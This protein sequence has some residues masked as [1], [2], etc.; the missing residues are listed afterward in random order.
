MPIQVITITEQIT[1]AW[2]TSALSKNGAL[3][4]GSVTSFEL[5]S[6]RGNWSAN[7]SL[8]INYTDDAQGKLPLRLFL[9][10]A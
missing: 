1:T 9:K 4:R 8:T 3:T 10:M 7:G 5:D 2:L 6:G